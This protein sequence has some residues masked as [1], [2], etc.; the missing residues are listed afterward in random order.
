MAYCIQEDIEKMLPQVQLIRLTD[1]ESGELIHAGRIQEA[2]ESASEEIDAYIGSRV[3][4]PIDAGTIPPILGKFCVDIAI[5]NLYSRIKENI[6]ETRAE[7]YKNVIK[8]LEKVAAG[9]LTLGLQPAPEPPGEGQCSGAALVSTRDKD[10]SIN[11][12]EKY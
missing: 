1:D 8:S 7:R 6:P 5:Y 12:L 4:L 3:K 2:L 9:K 10:F 11:N